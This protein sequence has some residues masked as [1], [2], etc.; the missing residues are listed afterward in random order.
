MDSVTLAK[1]V[2]SELLGSNST[3]FFLLLIALFA[4]AGAY[5]GKYLGIK[6]ANL[7]TKEDFSVLQLQLS[8]ST[9]LV[10]SVKSEIARTDWVAREWATLR[11]KKIEEL[12]TAL[13]EC[14]AYLEAQLTS[15]PDGKCYGTADPFSRTLAITELY[16]PELFDKVNLFISSCR[17]VSIYNSKVFLLFL[18][19]KSKGINNPSIWDNLIENN[20][21][22]EMLFAANEVRQMTSRL[23]QDIVRP[24]E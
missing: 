12:M 9:R 5:F 14:E 13:H 10:E 2:A 23:V 16:L 1:A 8:S 24:K 22:T 21:T 18:D 7:A 17:K 11:I 4:G 20:G 6:G 15:L 19:N 3:W